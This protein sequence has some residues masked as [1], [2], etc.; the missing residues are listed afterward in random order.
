MTFEVRLLKRA[1]GDIEDICGYLSQFYP[2][3]VGRFLVDLEQRLDDLAVHPFM[4]EEYR[5][6]KAY[7]RMVVDNYLVFYKVFK[8]GKTIRVYRILHGKRNIEAFLT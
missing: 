7:R 6:N 2:G 1:V 3:T 4:Y 5:E 8:S